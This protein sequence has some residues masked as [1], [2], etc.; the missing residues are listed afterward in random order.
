MEVKLKGLTNKEVERRI[1]ENG[2]NE[3]ISKKSKTKLE[4]IIE[5]LKDPIILI[6][7]AAFVL[8]IIT[9]LDN[10]HFG[11]AY[12]I[13]GLIVLNCVISFVQELK[14]LS[15]L[16]SLASMNEDT[17]TVIREGQK[18]EIKAKFLVI[19]DL[20]SLKIGDIVRA[21]LEVVESNELQVDEA[22]LTGESDFVEKHICETVFSNSAV[23][24]GTAIAVVIATGMNTE[25][26]KIAQKVTDVEDVKS[27]LEI[28]ILHITKLL[29]KIAIF[30]AVLIF[31]LTLLSGQ[32]IDEAFSFATS[33]LIATVPEGLA[34]VLTIVLTFMAT[35]I[36]KHNALVKKINLLETLGEV[37]YVCSDKT[38]TITENKMTVVEKQF[39]T[40][41]ENYE[42]LLHLVI[43][44]DSP[45][46][47]AIHEHINVVH[48]RHQINFDTGFKVVESIPFNSK[49]KHSAHILEIENMRFLVVVGA[50]DILVNENVL[51]PYFSEYGNQG[52]RPI[53]VAYKQ[54]SHDYD[55]NSN[56]QGLTPLCLFGIQDPPKQSA[57]STINEFGTAGITP[58]MITGD[59]KVTAT[60]IARQAGII[61]S[62]DDLVLSHAEL[63]E[64]SD[65]Q[66]ADIVMD[67]KVYARAKPE[68]K[69]RI[70]KAL[71]AKDQIVAMMG[72]GTNDSIALRQANIGIAM[73]INGTDISKEAADLILLDD[74]YSTID[75]GIQAG[76]L[77]FVNIRK[78]VRQMLTS[79]T[80][81]STTIMFALILDIFS[82]AHLMLPLTP[83]L[84]L[85]IN[86]VSDAIPCLALGLDDAEGDLMKTPPIDPKASILPRSMIV[87]ILLRGATIGLL[88]L[89]GFTY[90]YNTT[91]NLELAR[92]VGFIILSFGQ[93]I[94]IF[95]ARSTKTLYS[96][97]PFGNKWIIIT[98]LLSAVLNLSLVYTPISSTFGLEFI[99]INMLVIAI[100]ISSI[101]TF[102]YSL[103]KKIFIIKK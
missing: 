90:V 100:L 95:D 35:K 36:A 69:V 55:G 102:G 86:I 101:P 9:N 79:N 32:S 58:V 33:I 81:H 66:L 4:I 60:S 38:G 23:Q 31:V 27:Q 18:Q 51:E 49:Q 64:L 57:V 22:F 93:L 56:L 1:K 20:V 68:D 54:I 44:A 92:S 10:G 74:N 84:I 80:A 15:E 72:D 89:I 62:D 76:R 17:V 43:D 63:N 48:A 6:M 73:G 29:M 26:G 34:T 13:L 91:D 8:S 25:I 21:D 53:L 82:S 5:I 12:V 52:L 7:L 3:L 85:W 30:M 103:I 67:V 65:E 71:Q 40:S 2:Y 99:P 14:T 16:A 41:L 61:R 87:E 70:V 94:H 50:P 97:N 75:V 96:R 45:T 28:K 83:V 98:V 37:S 39:F 11:E 47:R 88:V 46:T 42:Q 77:I 24:N 59:N 19:D 78:F